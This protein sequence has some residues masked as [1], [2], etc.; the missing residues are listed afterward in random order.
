[1]QKKSS[2]V[3]V[4]YKEIMLDDN[5]PIAH[6][7][8]TQ[9]YE[10]GNRL[11][12]HNGVELGYCRRGNGVFFVGNRSYSF[13]QGDVSFIFADQPHIAQ[14]PSGL[15]S[16]WFYLVV[17]AERLALLLGCTP[18]PLSN[19]L[20][21]NC[22][23]RAVLSGA[24]HPALS[25]LARQIF[26]ELEASQEHYRT[27][28]MHLL[29]SLFYLV[30]RAGEGPVR[31]HAVTDSYAQI[32]PAIGHIS[33]HFSEEVRISDL[34]ALC[35]LSQP[36]FLRI[37]KRVMGCA[38]LEYLTQVRLKMAKTLIRATDSSITSVAERSGFSSISSFNR[39]FKSRFG[40]SPSAYKKQQ[41]EREAQS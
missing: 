12:F 20:P 40:V 16:E 23:L 30:L 2:S 8:H 9:G 31:S 21:E 14:S 17:D 37:F 15:E 38:P 27:V 41:E 34:S 10:S 36:Q 22:T 18:P 25:Q 26:E 7:R 3:Y 5:F 13:A 28:A 35:H 39:N 4:K 11:H 29:F 24:K 1:M 32:S 6:I 19:T 33:L